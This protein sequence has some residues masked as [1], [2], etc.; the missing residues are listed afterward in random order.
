MP[1][2]EAPT[3]SQLPTDG[4]NP[5]SACYH[6]ALWPLHPKEYLGTFL[7]ACFM[8]LANVSG[9]GGGGIAIPMIIYFFNL[10]FKPALAISSFSILMASLARYF[11]N[12]DERHPEKPGCTTIDYNVATVMMPLN[13]IGSLVGAYILNS[14]PELYIMI[15]MT[16]M[17]VVLTWESWSK[18][19]QLARKETAALEKEREMETQMAGINQVAAIDAGPSKAK[20]DSANKGNEVTESKEGGAQDPE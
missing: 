10:D 15:I 6:K 16:L 20:T 19:R 17:L 7:F 3:A 13:L 1:F 4:S 5:T 2:K 14:F 11:F 8:C 9:I 12:F 18:Y